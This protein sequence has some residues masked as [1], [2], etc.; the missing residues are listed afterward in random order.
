MTKSSSTETT[1]PSALIDS[2]ETLSNVWVTTLAAKIDI[3]SVCDVSQD[4]EFRIGTN[5]TSQYVGAL[6]SLI[7]ATS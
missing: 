2:S 5:V 7:L 3:D 6:S 1:S 4:G